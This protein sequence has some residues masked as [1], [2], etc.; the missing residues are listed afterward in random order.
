MKISGII[1]AGAV[2]LG[3]LTGVASAD[4]WKD[5]SGNRGGFTLQFGIDRDDD[6]W[7]PRRDRRERHAY[8]ERSRGRN[9]TTVREW[10][11]GEYREETRCGR[12]GPSAYYRRY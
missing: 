6:R 2:A 12:G 3:G 7:H 11:H 10:S 1:L 5:E 8:R 9:C 4:P